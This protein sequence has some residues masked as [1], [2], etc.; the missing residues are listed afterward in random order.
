MFFPL[1]GV[2]LQG[3]GV[4]LSYNHALVNS[5][6]FPV[7][8]SEKKKISKVFNS[9]ET[10]SS[11]LVAA[12]LRAKACSAKTCCVTRLRSAPL[13]PG[14]LRSL[15]ERTG[16]VVPK[17][18]QGNGLFRMVGKLEAEFMLRHL[19]NDC[20]LLMMVMRPC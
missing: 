13:R 20:F 6:S 9:L 8:Q 2:G 7:I 17:G 15:N 11:G 14:F 16:C 5:S 18:L 10:T 12:D 19:E 3:G 4:E 1:L